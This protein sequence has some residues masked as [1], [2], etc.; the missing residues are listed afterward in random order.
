MSDSG[1]AKGKKTGKGLLVK[2]GAGIAMIAAGGG[3]VFG[4]MAAGI[5]GGSGAAHAEAQGPQL[6]L[7]GEEDP[8][9]VALEGGHEGTG[10]LVHGDGGSRYRTAYFNFGDSFTSNLKNSPALIQVSLAAATQRD[11]RVLMWLN[12]HQLALRSRVLVEL[13]A[14][15]EQAINTAQGKADLQKRLTAAFNDELEHHEGFG[16][17][18]NVLF[19]ALI[20]Q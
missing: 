19:T 15:D 11:G 16:G 20:V 2:V 7:K 5:I 14:T 18:D 8:Y 4:L 17:V 1:E 10:D 13:A 3:G 12:E 6:V 9:P